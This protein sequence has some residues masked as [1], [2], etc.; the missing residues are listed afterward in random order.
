MYTEQV[1]MHL[2]CAWWYNLG[3]TPDNTSAIAP[4]V[5][6]QEGTRQVAI[7]LHSFM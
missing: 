6:P 1:S 3:N 7:E 4:K 5:T 2:R